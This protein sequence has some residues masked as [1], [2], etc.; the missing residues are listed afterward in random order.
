MVLILYMLFTTVLYC[1]GSSDSF[2][3]NI[4]SPSFPKHIPH[5]SN[6]QQSSRPS[7]SNHSLPYQLQY[8]QHKLAPLQNELYIT[9]THTAHSNSFHSPNLIW[10]P[11]LQPF[12]SCLCFKTQIKSYLFHKNVL[13]Q[14][15]PTLKALFSEISNFIICE[16]RILIA[17]YLNIP[18][19]CLYK[20]GI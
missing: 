12:K 8:F 10:H 4:G 6:P 20:Q 7:K 11:P 15:K 14:Q 18:Y 13:N 19:L 5:R 1:T 9:H 16:S 17:A 3:Q 2:S